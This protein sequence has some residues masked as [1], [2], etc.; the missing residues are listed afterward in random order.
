MHLV[1][2]HYF[3]IGHCQPS[4]G[5]WGPVLRF[6]DETNSE[7]WHPKSNLKSYNGLFV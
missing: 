3:E 5:K 6:V 2:F 4:I 7:P 1:N